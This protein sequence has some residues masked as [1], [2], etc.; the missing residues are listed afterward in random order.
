MEF[1]RHAPLA[2][3]AL[4][5]AR[6]RP[7]RAVAVSFLRHSTAFRAKMNLVSTPAGNREGLRGVAAHP[8]RLL[9]W[10]L[11]PVVSARGAG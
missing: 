1:G 10:T 8:P 7:L 11:A 5:I 3:S 4:R 9:R 2:A 6:D